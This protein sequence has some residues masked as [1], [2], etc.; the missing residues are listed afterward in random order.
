MKKFTRICLAISLAT[1]CIGAICMGAGIAFGSGPREVIELAERGGLNTGGWKMGK[2]LFYYGPDDED[3]VSVQKGALEAEFSEEEIESLDIEVR[4]GEVRLIDGASGRIRVR[5]DAPKKNAYQCYNDDGK[6]VLKDKTSSGI[7]IFS[8]SFRRKAT[9]TIEIPEG[10]LFGEAKL[11]TNAGAVYIEHALAAG[12]IDL[13]LDAGELVADSLS[14][15]GDFSAKVGAGSLEAE[16]F[17]AGEL[18]VECGMGEVDLCGFVRQDADVECGMGSISL[19]LDA[20]EA[21]YDYEISCGLGEV[22]INGRDYSSLST[23]KVI[24]NLAG[25][26]IRLECGM[27]EINF[28]SKED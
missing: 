5:I 25:R 20:K 3:D 23:D 1:A 22:E 14:A 17:F 8:G 24:D 6:L 18:D 12:E 26:K 7:G 21:D 11:V 10:K 28:L 15:D 19:R 9:V 4:Y 2:W 16:Q 13:E 27:G